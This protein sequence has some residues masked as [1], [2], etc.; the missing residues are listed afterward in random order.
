MRTSYTLEAYARSGPQV[1]GSYEQYLDRL[2]AVTASARE[3]PNPSVLDV[4]AGAGIHADYLQ[5]AG[6]MVTATDSSPHAMI[7]TSARKIRG[8]FANIQ[9]AERFDGIH[10]KD[11]VSAHINPDVFFAIAAEIIEPFGIVMVCCLQRDHHCQPIAISGS[12]H[13]FSM[14]D[15]QEWEPYPYETEW[16]LDGYTRRSIMVFQSIWG[17]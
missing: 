7:L 12:K 15:T 3:T 1:V 6:C 5:S 13:G 8:W 2:V 14:I 16:Y 10:A 17:G 4:G 11:V 9:W